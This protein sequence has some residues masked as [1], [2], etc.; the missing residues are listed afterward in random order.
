MQAQAYGFTYY[1]AGVGARENFPDSVPSFHYKGSRNVTHVVG[2]SG[3]CP[4]PLSHLT[5]SLVS[6][7]FKQWLILA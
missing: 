5:Y 3:K 7:L 4:Y 2:L 6:Y 1:N